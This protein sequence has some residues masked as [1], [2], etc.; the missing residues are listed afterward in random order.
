MS[1]DFRSLWQPR[2]QIGLISSVKCII[3]S[4]AEI[5]NSDELWE[6]GVNVQ[7]IVFNMVMDQSAIKHSAR[8]F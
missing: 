7:S 3:K 2:L 8:I 1:R 5:A 4:M 6:K